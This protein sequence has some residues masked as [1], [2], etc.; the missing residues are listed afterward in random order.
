MLKMRRLLHVFTPAPALTR[1]PT[2]IEETLKEERM[3]AADVRLPS[4]TEPIR[5]T[6][7]GA[8]AVAGPWTGGRHPSL[9]VDDDRGRS[10]SRRRTSGPRNVGMKPCTKA[11]TV[12]VIIRAT[13]GDGAEHQRALPEP[14]D[15]RVEHVSRR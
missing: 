14:D 4:R 15:A 12:L 9:L 1:P 6:T 2:V 11:C 10:P 13:G 7:L 3:G 8:V 5:S